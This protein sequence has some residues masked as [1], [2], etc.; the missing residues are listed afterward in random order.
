MVDSGVGGNRLTAKSFYCSV[1][2]LRASLGW[3]DLC[4][5]LKSVKGGYRI[6][7]RWWHVC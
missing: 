3:H 1:V 2:L 5:G 6:K 4:R 7:K